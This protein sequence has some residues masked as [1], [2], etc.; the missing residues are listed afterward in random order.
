MR[1]KQRKTA[2][3]AFS[4]RPKTMLETAQETGIYRA[5]LCRYIS[6][7]QKQNRIFLIHFGICPISKHRAGFYYTNGTIKKGVVLNPK[8]RLKG[9]PNRNT[10]EMKE[11]IKTILDAELEKVQEHLEQLEPK[12]RLDFITK[13][14]P[15]VVPKQSEVKNEVNATIQNDNSL[16]LSKLSD[17]EL[18]Q[19][20]VILE[21][22]EQK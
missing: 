13:L 9:T 11:A 12:E 18:E 3:N 8:G 16:D 5:N 17:K 6:E 20:E 15:Y 2:L 7:W 4:E 1:N 21:K 10:S 14:L 19:L 22:V